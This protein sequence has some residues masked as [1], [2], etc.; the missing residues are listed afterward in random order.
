MSSYETR[1][2]RNEH[3]PLVGLRPDLSKCQSD[4]LNEVELDLS[5]CRCVHNLLN[6]PIVR[7]VLDQAKDAGGNGVA[8]RNPEVACDNHRFSLVIRLRAV[9][10]ELSDRLGGVSAL[11]HQVASIQEQPRPLTERI[12]GSGAKSL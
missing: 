9:L 3:G 6:R 5:L 10:D 12:V 1:R 4:S 8:A 11:V 7:F 2:P